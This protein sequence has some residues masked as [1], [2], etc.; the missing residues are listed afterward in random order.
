MEC[1]VRVLLLPPNSQ[2]QFV[3]RTQIFSTQEMGIFL[4]EVCF[5]GKNTTMTQNIAGMY[6]RDGER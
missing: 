4:S 2:A 3:G 5:R 6:T 1:H